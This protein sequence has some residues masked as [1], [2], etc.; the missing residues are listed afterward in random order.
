MGTQGMTLQDFANRPICSIITALP[1]VHI[2][3]LGRR[4]RASPRQPPLPCSQELGP[5]QEHQTSS[6]QSHY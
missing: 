6:Y 3:L 2:T 5:F 1:I 4:A